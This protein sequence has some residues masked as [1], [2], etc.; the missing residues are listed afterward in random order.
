MAGCR[1]L[2]LG[3][4][5]GSV[6]VADFVHLDSR[7]SLFELVASSCAKVGRVS[8]TLASVADL[9]LSTLPNL[10]SFFHPLRRLLSPLKL[11]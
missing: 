5:F 8:F 2:V 3:S 4:W 9:L 10:L 6:L 7:S 11:P 1:F